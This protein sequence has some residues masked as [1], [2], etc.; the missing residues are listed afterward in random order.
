M[1]TWLKIIIY[2]I[3]TITLLFAG[4][5][6][7][8]QT[9]IFKNWLKNKIVTEVNK[10]LNASLSVGKIQ[11]NLL[12]HFQISD[13]S[14]ISTSTDTIAQSDGISLPDTIL[15]LPELTINFSPAR[16]LN[17]E[18]VIKLVELNSLHFRL[19]QM[20]D[21]SW[22]VEH[23]V[24]SKPDTLAQAPEPSQPMK[25]RIALNNMKLKDARFDFIPL[26][27]SPFIPQRIENINTQASLVFDRKG[28]EVDLKN[29]RLLAQNP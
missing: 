23:F 21:S 9:Q 2:F 24:I 5:V 7:F 11:G 22:N 27:E 4:V 13:I 8:T 1:R 12:T 15:T 26:R 18:I 6:F 28:V 17:K 10:N 20:P 25:W 16:L 3:L 14:L 19:R 29:F